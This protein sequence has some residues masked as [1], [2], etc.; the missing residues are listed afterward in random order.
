MPDVN[1]YE[2]LV[3]EDI[4]VGTGTAQKR[5]PGGGTQTGTQVGVHTFGVGQ[6]AV[7]Q[8]WDPPSVNSLGTTSTTVTVTGAAVGDYV[9]VSFS[10]PLSGLW[11]KGEVTAAN[12]VTVTLFNPTSSAVD[13]TS[14][15]L[16]VLVSKSR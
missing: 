6:Q 10:L 8:T 1:Y 2:T 12:T 9:D 15:T 7:P 4:D 11:I 13:L 5:M 16:K 3:Q 14:G